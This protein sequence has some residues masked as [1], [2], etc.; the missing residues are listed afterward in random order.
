MVGTVGLYGVI[1]VKIG[2]NVAL[3]GFVVAAESHTT[4]FQR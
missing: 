2:I 3:F 1:L 4:I